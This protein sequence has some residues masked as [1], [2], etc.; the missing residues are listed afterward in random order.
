M[1]KI[2]RTWSLMSACWQILK[3]DKEML[4]FPLISG[5]CCL[6]LLASFVLPFYLTGSWQPPKAGAETGHHVMYYG[7][8][9]LFY[10]CSYFVVVF[11][12]C[13]VVACATIRMSGGD[14]SV[15]DGIRAA[16]S[17]R[18]GCASPP[19]RCTLSGWRW[20]SRRCRRSFRR[21]CISA[22]ATDRCR[23]GSRRSFCAGRWRRG[24]RLASEFDE[25]GAAVRRTSRRKF[26]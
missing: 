16:A 6:L 22:R 24:K 17:R 25:S 12:N 8:T 19:R 4:L 1:N 2:Y 18:L 11:F 15:A 14:P 26:P 20:C 3:K 5:L 23:R 13:A 7:M 9:F 10:V 21:H